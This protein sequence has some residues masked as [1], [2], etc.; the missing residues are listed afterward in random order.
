[1]LTQSTG[2]PQRWIA[3]ARTLSNNWLRLS[4]IGRQ[5]PSAIAEATDA[6]FAPDKQETDDEPEFG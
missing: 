3:A 2:G 1:V 4:D 6:R 5:P